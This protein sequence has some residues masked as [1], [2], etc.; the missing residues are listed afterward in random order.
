MKKLCLSHLTRVDPHMSGVDCPPDGEFAKTVA[1]DECDQ[2]AAE[3][4]DAELK[5]RQAE[6]NWQRAKV[7]FFSSL[8]NDEQGRKRKQA[9]LDELNPQN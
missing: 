6:D 4:V 9:V 1:A 3:K 7:Q 2:C 8:P 5:D